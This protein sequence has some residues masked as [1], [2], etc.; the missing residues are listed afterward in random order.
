MYVYAHVKELTLFGSFGNGPPGPVDT[1]HEE[2]KNLL[3]E[4]WKWKCT[5]ESEGQ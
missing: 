4:Q 3:C 1:F 5:V 2:N